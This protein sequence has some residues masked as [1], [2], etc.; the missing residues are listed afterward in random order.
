MPKT[1]VGFVQPGWLEKMQKGLASDVPLA[2]IDVGR[3]KLQYVEVVDVA[4]DEH[5]HEKILKHIAGIKICRSSN[6]LLHQAQS[7]WG[8]SSVLINPNCSADLKGGTAEAVA[9]LVLGGSLE[10]R[11]LSSQKG[12][13]EQVIAR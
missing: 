12:V 8:W 2:A 7:E 6:V 10:A 3:N 4:S 1:S 5:V 11:T 9:G 13:H